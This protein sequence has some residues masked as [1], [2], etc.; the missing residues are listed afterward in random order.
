MEE[1]QNTQR[2]EEAEN[3]EVLEILI[4]ND[5]CVLTLEYWRPLVSNTNYVYIT[6]YKKIHIASIFGVM[7]ILLSA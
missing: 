2:Q 3:Q 6:N 1:A 5:K 7:V 4:I